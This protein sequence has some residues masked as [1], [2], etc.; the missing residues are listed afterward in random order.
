MQNGKSGE[1]TSVRGRLGK[2]EG[3]PTHSLTPDA[4]AKGVWVHE[5]QVCLG[6]LAWPFC[7]A[8]IGGHGCAGFYG[9]DAN[10]SCLDHTTVIHEPPFPNNRAA[11]DSG[12]YSFVGKACDPW[13]CLWEDHGV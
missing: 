10:F 5:Q 1:I 4:R 8:N 7:T 13:P 6:W 12:G 3:R 11:R 2:R 9:Y